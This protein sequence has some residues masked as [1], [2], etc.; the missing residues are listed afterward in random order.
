MTLYRADNLAADT[1]TTL[2]GG[3]SYATGIKVALQLQVPDN[4]VIKLVE[5][6][7][8]QDVATSTLTL[9][10]LQTTDTGSTGTTALST[11][12]VKPLIDRD[13]RASSLTMATTGSSYGNGALT[14]RTSLRDI[15]ALYVPQVFAF[16]WP[17]GREPIVG[18]GTGE[19]FLQ[20]LVNTTATVNGIVWVVW[21]E[22]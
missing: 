17:L 16:Q 14:S 21:D 1:T 7:W 2:G 20:V 11:T 5:F 8:S 19:N 18:S 3:A 22:P 9:L 13:G 6:G 12:L 15:H 4:Q 10:K